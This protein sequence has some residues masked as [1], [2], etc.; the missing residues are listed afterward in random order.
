MFNTTCKDCGTD[1]TLMV[2]GGKFSAYRMYLS[3]DGFS[4]SDAYGVDTE[5]EKVRCESCGKIRSLS[6]YTED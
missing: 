1:G 2:V 3:E 6:E 4:F 5:D